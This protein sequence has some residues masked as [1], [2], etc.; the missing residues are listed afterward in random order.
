MNKELIVRLNKSF[1]DAAYEEGGV[2]YWLRRE[3][4][5]LLG[6]AQ[7]RNFEQVVEKAKVSCRTAGQN[8]GHRFA[9]VSKTIPL[10]EF[11]GSAAVESVTLPRCPF[12]DHFVDVTERIDNRAHFEVGSKG[13]D[14]IVDV[15]EMVPIGNVGMDA[16]R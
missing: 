7:W 1:E 8:P 3:I 9:G 14:H 13:A 4:Q 16:M 5:A 11:H 15:T 12:E 2:E 6:C 10:R